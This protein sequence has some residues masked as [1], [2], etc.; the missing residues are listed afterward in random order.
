MKAGSM[1][2]TGFTLLF[3]IFGTNLVRG[4]TTIDVLFQSAVEQVGQVSRAESIRA[5]EEIISK[6]R[7]YAPAYNALANL[8]LQANTVN[9]RQRAAQMI[10]KAIMI[11]PNNAEYRLTRGKIWWHQ[12]LSISGIGTNS[13]T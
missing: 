7:N 4:E 8:Y 5:F 13:R 10:L 3:C 2:Y 6:D 1:I 9:D 12:G 11:D